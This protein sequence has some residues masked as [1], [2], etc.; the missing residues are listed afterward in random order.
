[1]NMN[2]QDKL[3]LIQQLGGLT[4]EKLAQKLDVSFPTINSWL[5]NKSH[6]RI[7]K[8]K[9]INAL[10]HEYSGLKETEKDVL[11]IKWKIIQDK[12][13]KYKDI[14]R[15][16]LKRKDLYEQFVLSL[17]YNTNR[18]EGSTLTE[19]E[20]AAILFQNV[21]LSNRTIVEQME[22]KNH[23][24][25]LDYLFRFC[26]ES[27]FISQDFIL[28]LHSILLNGIQQD[29]G[30]YR[31][32]GVRIVGSNVPTANCIKIPVL[33][34][35]L[36]K[37]INA[38]HKN[39][40]MHVASVHSV[41]EK[42]HPFSDGNGRVGRLICHC[43]LLKENYPPVVI[44]QRKKISYLKYLNQAQLKDEFDGLFEFF[45]DAVLMGF[46]LLEKDM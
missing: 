11:F 13:K 27:K 7:K 26:Q 24:A 21:A 41:F 22:A 28:R 4:Q 46:K 42:I 35:K 10:Y 19:P 18:I 20:T 29:A 40:V 37:D 25:A 33:M 9:S 5:N 3:K 17:T 8:E 2:I 44:Q 39:V 1:M 14:L 16:I 15:S 45:Y 12:Q 31:N 43:M 34:E 32:H 23:Q 38:S 30:Q 6:P 36:V